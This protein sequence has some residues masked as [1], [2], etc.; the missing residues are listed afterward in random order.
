MAEPRSR[1]WQLVSRTCDRPPLWQRTLV[2]IVHNKFEML[3][4]ADAHVKRTSNIWQENSS[5]FVF[6][7]QH[8]KYAN[9]GKST[10]LRIPLPVWESNLTGQH[11]H[12]HVSLNQGSLFIF[13]LYARVSLFLPS[14]GNENWC[15]FL[16]FK[17]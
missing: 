17:N 12:N 14:I 16:F 15:I 9:K 3:R 13:Y 7:P 2:F 10:D 8:F 5:W 6:S 1:C 4:W 11:S